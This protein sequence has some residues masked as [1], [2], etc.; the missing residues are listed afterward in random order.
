MDK[1]QPTY[2]TRPRAKVAYDLETLTA[3]SSPYEKKPIAPKHEATTRNLATGDPCN[4][5][6]E[7]KTA[8]TVDI[9]RLK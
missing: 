4:K 9:I 3:V 8:N 6:R 5:D 2:T 1:A 7:M